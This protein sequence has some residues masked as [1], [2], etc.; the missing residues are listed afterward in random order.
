AATLPSVSKVSGAHTGFHNAF[1]EIAKR[2]S[3]LPT[4]LAHSLL[5]MFF[6]WEIIY[7]PLYLYQHVGMSWHLVGFV[8]AASLV[9]YVLFEYPLGALADKYFGEKEMAFFGFIIM[10]L[11]MASFGFIQ[12][13]SVFPWIIA[14]LVADVGGAMVEVST[15]THFFKRVSVM[16][17][18]LVSAFRMLRP[19]A[20]ITAP[21]IASLLLLV[22]PFQNIFIAFGLIL[23][24]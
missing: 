5:L 18:N 19:F 3:L 7:V 8:F 17:A 21:A 13:T 1:Q 22:L 9:P 16:D 10:A 15:E 14:V 24:C 12:S 11:G 20:S 6:A 4:V 23:L 2:T